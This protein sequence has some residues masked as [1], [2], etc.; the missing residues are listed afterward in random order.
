MGTERERERER[1][2]LYIVLSIHDLQAAGFTN[3]GT[4]ADWP[5]AARFSRK[6]LFANCE[7]SL[8]CSK[9]LKLPESKVSH[10]WQWICLSQ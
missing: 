8:D 10:R 1:E 2:S 7:H 6:F 3:E 5:I 4:N 9:R